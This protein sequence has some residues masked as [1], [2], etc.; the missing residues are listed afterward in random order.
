[1]AETVRDCDQRIYGNSLYL[2]L[3]FAVYL[4][5]LQNI[6]FIKYAHTYIRKTKQVIIVI[7]VQGRKFRKYYKKMQRIQK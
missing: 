4:K 6:K 7:N 2:P 5:L 3:N 1:M